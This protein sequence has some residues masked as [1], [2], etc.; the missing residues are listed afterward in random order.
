M[1]SGLEKQRRGDGELQLFLFLGR[2]KTD[3][4][5]RS[6]RLARPHTPSLRKLPHAPIRYHSEDSDIAQGTAR[7]ED[8]EVIGVKI[9]GREQ[10]SFRARFDQIARKKSFKCFLIFE[11]HLNPKACH[12]GTALEELTFGPLG[13]AVEFSH[14]KDALNVRQRDG[15]SPAFAVQHLDG[16][17]LQIARAVNKAFD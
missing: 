12:S 17:R 3:L 7:N 4:A 16:I 6:C 14:E 5:I 8:F 13:I 9:R 10:E 2:E 15:Q 1:D 11:G